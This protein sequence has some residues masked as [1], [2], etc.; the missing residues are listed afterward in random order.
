MPLSKHFVK[1]KLVF[2]LQKRVPQRFGELS[3]WGIDVWG[4]D[5]WGIDIT[6]S[7][8]ISTYAKNSALIP[9]VV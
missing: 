9:R 7:K 3:F 4:I 6:P 5:F 1:K 2:C 8:L